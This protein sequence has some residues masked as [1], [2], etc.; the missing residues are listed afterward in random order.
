M[1]TPPIIIPIASGAG[2]VGKSFLTANLG[3]ALAK[4]GLRTVVADLDLGGSNL[5]RFLGVSNR[6]P[7]LGDWVTSGSPDLDH[8]LVDIGVPNLF[9]LPGDGKT[10]FMA[11]IPHA[12]KEKLLSRLRDLDAQVVL[13]DLSTGTSFNTLD[14]FAISPKGLVVTTPDPNAVLKLLT[15][16]RSV[17][18]RKIHRLTAR[19][20]PVQMLL[21][22][23]WGKPL[24]SQN[25]SLSVLVESIGKTD[26]GAG[27][28]VSEFLGGFRPRVV[29]NRGT[30]PDDL[31]LAHPIHMCSEK[32]LSIGVDFFGFIYEDGWVGRSVSQRSPLMIRHPDARAA[33]NVQRIAERIAGYWHTAIPGSAERIKARVGEDY[34]RE[35]AP[36]A[37]K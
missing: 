18:L 25:P 28:M 22:D 24:A 4:M 37:F 12:R 2:G 14:F 5:H 31:A 16:L 3:L 17:L 30:H 34:D 8:L 13:L 23:W 10:P 35:A 26:A 29:F 11:N 19:N 15:F 20:H 33:R 36:L 7:G 9:F 32:S 27:G 21:D 6:H 1:K